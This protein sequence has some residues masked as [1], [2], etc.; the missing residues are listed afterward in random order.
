M[1]LEEQCNLSYYVQV[2][3]INEEHEVFLVQ[4]AVIFVLIVVIV[5]ALAV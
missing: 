4:H 1:N 5:T 2:A 3:S